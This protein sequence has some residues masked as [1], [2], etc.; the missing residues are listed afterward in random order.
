MPEY[1]MAKKT[2]G[3]ADLGLRIVDLRGNNYNLKF[4]IYDIQT[5][6]GIST[7]GK[8]NESFSF[9]NRLGTAW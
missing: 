9:G 3:I 1:S 8:C 6:H 2:R 5:G 7:L 4:I